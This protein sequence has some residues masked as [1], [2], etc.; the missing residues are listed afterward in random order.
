[1]MSIFSL[2]CGLI[3]EIHAMFVK[4]W[5]GSSNERRKVHWHSRSHMCLPKGKG[6]MGF[7][8][9]K[10]FNVALLAKQSWHLLEGTNPLL[11]N[12]LKARYF[13]NTSVLEA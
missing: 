5:W 2:P 6:G 8:G 1:M 11:L 7:H 3:D 10:C 13:K 9:L 12:V 4:F